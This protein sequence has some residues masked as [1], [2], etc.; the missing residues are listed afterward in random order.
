M[1]RNY[2]GEVYGCLTVIEKYT[3]SD[4]KILTKCVCNKFVRIPPLH[5][6]KAKN[7]SCGCMSSQKIKGI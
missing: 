1:N 2:L 5:M 6:K 4:R 7:P 3:H